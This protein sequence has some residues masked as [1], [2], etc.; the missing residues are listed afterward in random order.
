MDE[1][2]CAVPLWNGLT[3]NRRTGLLHSRCQRKAT[4]S[5][6]G[7]AIPLCTQHYNDGKKHGFANTL[8][9][10]KKDDL[11]PEPGR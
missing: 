7:G 11:D 4:R 8:P 2:T 9:H 5:A 10:V 3:K 6:K 1:R